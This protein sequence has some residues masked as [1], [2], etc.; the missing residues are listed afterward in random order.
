VWAAGLGATPHEGGAS[1]LLHGPSCVQFSH[2][3]HGR[4]P[5]SWGGRCTA[6]FARGWSSSKRGCAGGRSPSTAPSPRLPRAR[7]GRRLRR[8][9]AA[10]ITRSTDTADM[11]PGPDPSDGRGPH[12]CRSR[13]H[14]RA[15]ASEVAREQKTSI[16]GRPLARP[17]RPRSSW[18]LSSAAGP[19][20]SSSPSNTPRASSRHPGCPQNRGRFKQRFHRPGEA[21]LHA[22][23]LAIGYRYLAALVQQ[24]PT[25][26]NYRA[27]LES[28]AIAAWTLARDPGTGPF[29]NDWAGP[30]PMTSGD[31]EAQSSSASAT[32]C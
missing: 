2:R 4:S 8:A 21:Q 24:D 26:T 14:V 6:P 1:I 13:R 18:Q 3:L 22:Q 16:S 19:A 23:L 25:Y 32:N 27:V 15:V 10:R 11:A 31:I 20:P 5:F 29:A 9:C 17:R 7:P 12:K 30:P 28:S